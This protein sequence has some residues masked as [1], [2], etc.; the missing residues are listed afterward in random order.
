MI[1]DTIVEAME[2]MIDME[3]YRPARFA[4]GRL[5]DMLC[6]LDPDQFCSMSRQEKQNWLRN[7]L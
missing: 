7:Y 2:M 1:T 6:N 4:M 5:M 3:E